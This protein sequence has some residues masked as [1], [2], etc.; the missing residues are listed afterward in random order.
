M[1]T[2][3]F[4]IA[5]KMEEALKE[6]KLHLT[7]GDQ[8]DDDQDDDQND[9]TDDSSADVGADVGDSGAGGDIGGDLGGG[10]GS[11]DGGS[12]EDIEE[13]ID[14]MQNNV[15]VEQNVPKDLVL[16]DGTSTNTSV[17]SNT[18]VEPLDQDKKDFLF[19]FGEGNFNEFSETAKEYSQSVTSVIHTLV[20]LCEKA[21]IELFGNSSS[22]KR[23]LFD[24]KTSV[25]NDTT[26][27][28]VN[29]RYKATNWIGNDIPYAAIQADKQHVINTISVVPG[30][31][32][33]Q[34]NIDTNTGNLDISVNIGGIKD[35]Q[36]NPANAQIQQQV[37]KESKEEFY[38]RLSESI[39]DWKK[40]ET[41]DYL[42]KWESV[43][44]I[45]VE[46]GVT[47]EDDLELFKSWV[48]KSHMEELEDGDEIAFLSEIQN[49]L[50][51]CGCE[52]SVETAERIYEELDK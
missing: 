3:I 21:L 24:A 12:S 51:L 38:E 31:T 46:S 45:L 29:L 47:D 33:K 7:E 10:S 42:N 30:I 50:E 2:N 9:N 27:I 26:S 39:D 20:P 6:K 43:K 36:E 14:Q 23:E 40:D 34:V 4:D 52:N 1:S 49:K 44:Q 19:Q 18:Q 41:E 35:Q 28:D 32:V 11:G 15:E 8:M 37:V 17:D 13:K 16:N 22:Y 5:S 25:N 48:W